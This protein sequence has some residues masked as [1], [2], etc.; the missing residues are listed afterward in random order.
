MGLF[1]FCFL[2]TLILFYF[3]LIFSFSELSSWPVYNTHFQKQQEE[4]ELT[5]GDSGVFAAPREI[6]EKAERI[7][8]LSQFKQS[9]Q[10]MKELFFEK[11]VYFLQTNLIPFNVNMLKKEKV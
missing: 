1:L 2:N 3:F 4:T 5:S 6:F 10:H 11:V 7:C 9:F 8:Q